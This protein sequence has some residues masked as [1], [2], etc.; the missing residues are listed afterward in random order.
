M[1][2]SFTDEQR[3]IADSAR[4]VLDDLAGAKGIE[5]AIAS[6][7]GYEHELWQQLRAELGWGAL[8]VP[9]SFDGM[10]LGAVEVALVLE[11]VGRT[12]AVSPYLANAL[13][14]EVLKVLP[15]SQTGEQ[16]LRQIASGE[17]WFGIAMPSGAEGWWSDQATDGLRCLDADAPGGVLLCQR[18]ED[19]LQW[20]L[21][22][23]TDCQGLFRRIDSFDPSHR[24]FDAERR[25]AMA[26]SKPL[27]ALQAE[28][29]QQVN[30]IARLYLAAEQLGD[31]QACLD[32]TAAHVAERTQFGR[33]LAG[34]QAV[35]HRCA[36]MMVRIETLR[37]QV[38]GAAASQPF[39]SRSD[40]LRDC[41]AARALSVETGFWCAQEAIQL[42]GGVGFT[43]EYQPHWHFKRAQA[44][45]DWL[46]S[47]EA[48]QEQLA[49][50]LMAQC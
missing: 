12:L 37:S 32:L 49:Q 44:T 23:A 17:S 13:A 1:D 45:R 19:L 28:D 2:F 31:A 41:L 39:Q 21:L 7:A 3:L 9:E 4:E 42:H 48:L 50:Q 16:S 36:E 5:R 15:D 27:A 29:A 24:L 34:F 26:A 14:S 40:F 46:G 20:H 25:A 6:E 38:H 10:G 43:W 30:A 22:E 8:N 47:A 33:V 11:Q 35:K 18:E